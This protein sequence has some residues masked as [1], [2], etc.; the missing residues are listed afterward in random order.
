MKKI[1]EVAVISV[2]K[3]KQCTLEGWS[4]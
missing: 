4:Q 2:Q 3:D 1:A